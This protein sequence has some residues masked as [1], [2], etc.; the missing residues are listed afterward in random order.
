MLHYRHNNFYA[1]VT[2]NQ[3]DQRQRKQIINKETDTAA[4]MLYSLKKETGHETPKD[5]STNKKNYEIIP[6]L[7]PPNPHPDMN[8]PPPTESV[9][10]LFR[11]SLPCFIYH[12][13]SMS[14]LSFQLA[15]LFSLFVIIFHRNGDWDHFGVKVLRKEKKTFKFAKKDLKFKKHNLGSTNQILENKLK[16]K[17]NQHSLTRK[18]AQ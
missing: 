17:K 2:P 6:T 1:P 3:R 12:Q 13:T 11:E 7:C 18:G 9:L 10:I 8:E 14:S 16:K 15:D 4:I 5:K